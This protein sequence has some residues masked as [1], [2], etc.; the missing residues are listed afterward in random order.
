MD[1]HKDLTYLGKDM[2]RKTNPDKAVTFVSNHDTE[3]DTNED[4]S[5]SEE[6]KMNAYAY[7]LTH[8][9]FPTIFYSD[10]EN[11]E[12]QDELKQLILIHNTL[13]TGE[14]EVLYNDDDEYI[15]KRAGQGNNPGLIF[16]MNTSSNTKRRSVN[17]NWTDTEI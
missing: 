4:N 8:D 9:G 5:I 1:R 14:V 15:M 13:A 7:T 10:Y 3:K 17:T 2:L 16:Y 6:N 11:E 12:F